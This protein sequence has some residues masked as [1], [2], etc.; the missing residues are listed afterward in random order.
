MTL[1]EAIKHCEEK[2]S[3]CNKCANEHRQLEEWLL[4]LKE[5]RERDKNNRYKNE[6]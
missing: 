2:S 4:E 3:D 1:E 5:R 6:G